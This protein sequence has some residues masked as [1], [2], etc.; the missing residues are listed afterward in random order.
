MKY[1]E[2]G[3]AAERHLQTCQRL[4]ELIECNTLG[5]SEKENLL[6]NLFYLT[7][8]IV[9]CSF[10]FAFFAKIYRSGNLS[11]D[12]SK[13]KENADKLAEIY[14]R[15]IREKKSSNFIELN[16]EGNAIPFSYTNHFSIC[17]EK[18]EKA[19]R[20][21]IHFIEDKFRPTPVS[22]YYEFLIGNSTNEILASKWHS[23]TRY[24]IDFK[25]N[26]NEVFAYIE[27]AERI[28]STSK[29]YDKLSHYSK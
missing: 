22:N 16:K 21:L 3:Y 5:K 19:S 4:K 12:K 13:N 11:K 28:F 1:T 27:D 29:K 7:G 23:E 2:F 14:N 8:Y 26:Q 24:F 10:K 25:L 6:K 9:E 18:H 20:E 17:N 15:S